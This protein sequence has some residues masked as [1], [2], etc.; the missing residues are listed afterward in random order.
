MT[1]EKE[2][3]WLPEEA[4]KGFLDMR[5]KIKKPLTERAITR[6]LNKLERMHLEGHNIQAVLEQSEDRCWADVY[7]VH[8]IKVVART[9]RMEIGQD[10]FMQRLTDTSW[11]D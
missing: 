1:G 2:M 4:W 3:E 7:P 8:G 9:A 10:A 5:K 6:M 11:A